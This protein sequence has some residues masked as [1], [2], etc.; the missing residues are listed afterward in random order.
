MA[1]TIIGGSKAKETNKRKYGQDYY[2]KIGA[3]GGAK[4][5]G[6]GFGQGEEGRKRAKLAGAK[7]GRKSRRGRK[8]TS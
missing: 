1:G 5:R 8:H 4:S 6:G 2:Q 3:L 7:G